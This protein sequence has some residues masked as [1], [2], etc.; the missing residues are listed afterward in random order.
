MHR[1]KLLI[2]GAGPTG[3][4]A[5]L[6]ATD[7]GEKD[8]AILE[9]ARSAGGLATSVRDRRGFTWDLGAHVQFSHY[10]KHDE[11]LD[12]SL[13]SGDWLTHRRATWVYTKRRF[14]PYPYQLNLQALPKGDRWEALLGMLRASKQP[15]TPPTDFRDWILRTFGEGI[16]RQFLLP[17]NEKIWGVPLER[18]SADWVSERVAAP[19][20]EIVLKG[21]CF[22]QPSTS[23][24]PN[25]TFRYPR[26]GGTGAIWHSL[27]TQLP[28]GVIRYGERV[29]AIDLNQRVVFTERGE[30]FGYENLVSTMPLDELTRVVTPSGQFPLA[31]QLV[32]TTTHVVGLGL[33]GPVPDSLRGKFWIYFPDSEQP[34]YR[35]TVLSNLSQ[36]MVPDSRR[37]WSVMAEVAET[38]HR[39]LP[40]DDV[41]GDVTRALFRAGLIPPSAKVESTWQRRL[42]HGYPVPTK[43]RDQILDEVLPA[44]A[45]CG[46]Y[47]RGRFGGWKYEVSNQDHSLMQ[48]VEAVERILNGREELTFFRPSL[49]NS[50]TNPFPYVEWINYQKKQGA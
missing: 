8:I 18:M 19:D 31:S 40:S 11:F 34:F 49:I 1:Y 46:I 7:V 21:V 41:A 45:D 16:G 20:L 28:K 17:Y 32:H 39:P 13:S 37:H 35:L 9:A 29:R 30:R 23:W 36:A 44:L 22:N 26:V 3:L 2:T 47:S 15:R 6:H 50:R 4:G 38:E 5:A 12:R 24:G 33:S 48:G 27:A 43:E 10:E 42:H 14:I 25:A